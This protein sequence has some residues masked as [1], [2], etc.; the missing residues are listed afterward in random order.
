MSKVKRGL[1][2]SASILSI[3]FGAILLIGAIYL[4]AFTID[5]GSVAG[6]EGL[7][8]IYV[9]YGLI[10]AFCI[11][12]IVVCACMCPNPSKKGKNAKYTGLIITALVF[13]CILLLIYIL[14]A[15]FWA[16]MP[17]I[18]AGLFIAALCIKDKPIEESITKNVE[19]SSESANINDNTQS[20]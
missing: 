13:N 10:I 20:E 15:S 11:A 3:V 19:E 17:L 14:E 2:L 12:L 18:S 8:I 6:V 9:T 5:A 1:Q 16:I 4:I 7:G